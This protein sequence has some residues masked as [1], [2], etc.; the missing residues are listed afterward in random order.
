MRWGVAPKRVLWQDRRGGLL[1]VAPKRL[2]RTSVED[3][4][5]A[6]RYESRFNTSGEARYGA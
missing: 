5:G 1:G 3:C 4:C 6:W 2:H